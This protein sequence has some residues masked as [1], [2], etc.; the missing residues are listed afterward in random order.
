[1]QIR[2]PQIIDLICGLVLM[3]LCGLLSVSDYIDNSYAV[4]ASDKSQFI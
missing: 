4:I 1:M 2:V 3:F